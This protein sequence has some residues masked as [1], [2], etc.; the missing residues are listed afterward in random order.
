LSGC[1]QEIKK[2]LE[3]KRNHEEIIRIE[4]DKYLTLEIEFKRSKKEQ[5]LL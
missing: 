2:I 1:E 5:E 3:E 4:K